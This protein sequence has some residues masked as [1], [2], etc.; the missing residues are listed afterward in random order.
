MSTNLYQSRRNLRQAQAGADSV[1]RT[2]RRYKWWIDSSETK[3]CETTLASKFDGTEIRQSR[4]LLSL[5]PTQCGTLYIGTERENLFAINRERR[6]PSLLTSFYTLFVLAC[7]E[8]TTTCSLRFVPKRKQQSGSSYLLSSNASN[9]GS[10]DNASNL[11]SIAASF[12]PQKASANDRLGQ[13]F[14]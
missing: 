8:A 5:R 12:D 13:R 11:T 4:K 1:H 6:D 14:A 10:I 9:W 7:H 3:G 2:N